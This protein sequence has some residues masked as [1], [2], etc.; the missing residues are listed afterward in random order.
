MNT[1]KTDDNDI[2]NEIKTI[3]TEVANLKSLQQTLLKE[4]IIDL[5]KRQSNAYSNMQ[6]HSN[7]KTELEEHL[8]ST[9]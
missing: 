8:S 3:D 7:N 9:K 6:V 5:I 2:C 1:I 4:E